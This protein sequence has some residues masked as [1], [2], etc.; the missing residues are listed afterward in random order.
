MDLSDIRLLAAMEKN[1]RVSLKTLA[2]ELSV[3]T[4]TIYH[5][6]HKLK[7]SKVI[8]HFTIALNPEEIGLTEYFLF[9]L[10]LKKVVIGH[11]DNM[12]LESFAKFL[13]DQYDEILFSAV[14]DDEQVWLLTGFRNIEH[15]RSFEK[16]LKENP[17]IENITQIQFPKI[18]KGKKVFSFIPSLFQPTL[19]K[20][21][22]FDDVSE[23]LD[24]DLDM[25]EETDEEET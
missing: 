7:E 24:S 11:L 1:S 5:R 8:D 9:A 21:N 4:S 15:Y 13:S 6:L 22:L 23:D 10:R 18:L 3:K 2:S 12:F 14:G 25:E 16:Q 19:L 17:Y 20:G